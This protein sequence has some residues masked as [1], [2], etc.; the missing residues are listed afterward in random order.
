MQ[1][2]LPY[3]LHT[4]DML[5]RGAQEDHSADR[6]KS[7]K[8]LRTAKSRYFVDPSKTLRLF[9][10]L[11]SNQTTP[12][13]TLAQMSRIAI[14]QVDVFGRTLTAICPELKTESPPRGAA[15]LHSSL[16]EAVEIMDGF[17]GLLSRIREHR[18]V[19]AR[20]LE[21]ISKS[22]APAAQIADSA[23]NFAD[24]VRRRRNI[25]Y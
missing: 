20:T 17:L 13:R 8:I 9:N 10:A 6:Q 14:K 21:R 15:R 3:S 4:F 12:P 5:L 19:P 11:S 25:Q 24:L 22:Y 18:N 1:R 16:P 23:R 2:A 7:I